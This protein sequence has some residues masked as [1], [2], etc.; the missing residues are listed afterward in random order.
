MQSYI[1]NVSQDL[2]A[3]VAWDEVQRAVVVSFRG[4]L[5]NS[6]EDWIHDL[7]FTK[8]NP[9]A[10]YPGAGVHHGFWEA[11]KSLEFGVVQAV[12]EIV[13]VH[14]ST[15]VLVTG[16][17]MGGAIA[18]DAAIDLKLTHGFATS[19]MNFE[20]PRAGDHNFM[21]AMRQ[22]VPTFWRVTHGN[23]LVPHVPP[24]TFGFYHIPG[25]VFFPSEDYQNLTYVVCDGSG[26]DTDCSNR[27]SKALECTSV[28]D[29]LHLMGFPLG[30][31]QCAGATS[32]AATGMPILV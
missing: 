1:N 3:F 21:E 32:N 28:D 2:A 26:E 24:E 27:C 6:I 18:A 25:E 13:S 16:H 8:S 15:V 29:H 4:T 7:S 22:E 9:I 11:W 31:D 17:S 10:R 20:S 5:S 30:S 23:D 14:H 12:N 19:V